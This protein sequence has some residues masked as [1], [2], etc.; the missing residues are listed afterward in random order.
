MLMYSI[1]RW[2]LESAWVTTLMSHHLI[3]VLE[4][5]GNRR[6]AQLEVTGSRH[7]LQR[8]C[9]SSPHPLLSL[10]GF[11]CCP[12][13]SIMLPCLITGH[14]TRAEASEIMNKNNHFLFSLTDFF[15][16][17]QWELIYTVDERGLSVSS[18]H[19]S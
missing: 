17:Q 4:S 18:T 2:G 19:V 6:K 11:A 7:A 16:S 5:E 13:L 8:I 15:L 1:Q 9:L 3:A 12:I 10:T 14:E